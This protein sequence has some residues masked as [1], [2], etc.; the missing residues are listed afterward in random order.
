MALEAMASAL[1]AEKLPAVQAGKRKREVDSSDLQAPVQGSSNVKSR[2]IDAQQSHPWIKRTAASS[3][4]STA[5]AA[6]SRRDPAETLR[7]PSSTAAA[8]SPPSLLAR[9]SPRD[10]LP[11]AKPQP[12]RRGGHPARERRLE[13]RRLERLAREGEE[14]KAEQ[15]KIA[16]RS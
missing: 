15:A 13:R 7:V 2:A 9:M 3:D 16:N 14:G 1:V 8:V 12:R 10:E 4:S 5:K 6:P 11:I